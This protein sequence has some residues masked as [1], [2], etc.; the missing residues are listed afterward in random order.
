MTEK[1][2]FNPAYRQAG[3][4]IQVPKGTIQTISFPLSVGM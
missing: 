2:G 1:S 3:G 4:H